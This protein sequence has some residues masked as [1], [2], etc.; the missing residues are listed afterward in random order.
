MKYEGIMWGPS[1]RGYLADNKA[2]IGRCEA[3]LISLKNQSGQFAR[4]HRMLLAMHREIGAVLEK[5]IEMADTSEQP[6]AHYKTGE[7]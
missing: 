6:P 2:R 4:E 3:S 7:K 5:H 1:M